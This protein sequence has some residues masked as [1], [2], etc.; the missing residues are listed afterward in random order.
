MCYLQD[1]VDS[2]LDQQL[3][4]SCQGKYNPYSF[5]LPVHLLSLLHK[6]Q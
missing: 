5:L 6:Y 2:C 4:D 1:T 3:V